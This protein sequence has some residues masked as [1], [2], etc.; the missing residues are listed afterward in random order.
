VLHNVRARGIV[1]HMTTT[2]SKTGLW[3]LDAIVGQWKLERECAPETAAEWLER[4]RRD[5]PAAQFCL[6]EKRPITESEKA[7]RRYQ[8]A[9]RRGAR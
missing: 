2:V 6:S 8:S 1:L 5:E 3:K 9:R 7:L 4:F